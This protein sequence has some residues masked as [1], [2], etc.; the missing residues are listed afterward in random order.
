LQ[1]PLAR[2]PVCGSPNL[3]P[4]VES[5]VQEVHFLCGDCHRCWHVELGFVHRM[6]PHACTG[7]AH[8]EQC[9]AVY[10]ADHPS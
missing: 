8:A 3:A 10:A 7:C 4:V 2:C 5:E 9:N 1:R 6:N